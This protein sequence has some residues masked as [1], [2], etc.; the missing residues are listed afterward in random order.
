MELPEL[1]SE[2]TSDV[3]A[4]TGGDVLIPGLGLLRV[5][6]LFFG[7]DDELCRLCRRP[8]GAAGGEDEEDEPAAA[9]PSAALLPFLFL[10]EVEDDMAADEDAM[11]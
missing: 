5:L 9:A 1:V 7:D 10:R 8:A 2:L 11:D 4:G 3:A 6:L